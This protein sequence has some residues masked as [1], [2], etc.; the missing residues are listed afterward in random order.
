MQKLKDDEVQASLVN[1]EGWEAKENSI[2]KDFGF[3]GFSTAIEFIIQLVPVTEKLNHH[4]T[5][6]NSYNRVTVSL[7][8]HSAKGLT[9]TDFK[10]AQEADN[11]ALQLRR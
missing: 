7:T 11:I 2:V 10:F 5:I 4:P 8:T 9:K 1:L 3:K 6:T